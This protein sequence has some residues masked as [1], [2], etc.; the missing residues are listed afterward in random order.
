MGGP[1]PTKFQTVA[2]S[3]WLDCIPLLAKAPP[4][5]PAAAARGDKAFHD[6]AGAACAACHSGPQF[7][8]RAVVDVGTGGKFKVPSLLGVGARA[9]FLHDGRASTLNHRFGPGG[10]GDQHGKTSDLTLETIADLI[11]YLETL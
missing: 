10:G 2:L 3:S 8:S 4:A 11:V 7:T 6:L 5:D 1:I 9:P